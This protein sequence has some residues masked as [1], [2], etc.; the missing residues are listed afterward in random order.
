MSDEFTSLVDAFL[1][2]PKSLAGVITSESWKL[3]S[4]REV[5]RLVLP[6]EVDGEVSGPFVQVLAFPDW[7]ILRFK[8]NLSMPPDVWRVCFDPEDLH[9]NARRKERDNVPPGVIGSHHHSWEANKRFVRN[10]GKH[11][12]LENAVP[13]PS[14]LTNFDETFLWFCGQINVLNPPTFALPQRETLI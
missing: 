12:E 1:A 8:I 13:L 9:T 7:H 10:A 4:S 5:R 14:E 2:K 3:G 6:L 11:Q